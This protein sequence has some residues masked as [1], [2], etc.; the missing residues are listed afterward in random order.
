MCAERRSVAGGR[1]RRRGDRG[2]DGA[3]APKVTEAVRSR[4]SGRIQG[5]RG[6]RERRVGRKAA[7]TAQFTA[8]AQKMNRRQTP[9]S[10]VTARTHVTGPV[11]RP[12][13]RGWRRRGLLRVARAT[14]S[15]SLAEGLPA[16]HLQLAAVSVSGSSR[17]RI[18][19]RATVSNSI[20]RSSIRC[21][22]H[23][24]SSRI[25]TAGGSHRL[26]LLPRNPL[27]PPDLPTTSSLPLLSSEATGTPGNPLPEL[28]RRARREEE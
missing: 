16:V 1:Q 18:C 26:A 12:P 5:G 7:S 17:R 19:R 27:P 14:A 25:P 28:G 13:C 6:K 10:V 20:S 23:Q 11:V 4:T 3:S 21:L 15:G 2:H 9:S 22:V 8:E 24:L